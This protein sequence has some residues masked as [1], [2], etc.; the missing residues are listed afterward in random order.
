MS[1]NPDR[2]DVVS[3]CTGDCRFRI[4]CS[5]LPS[6]RVKHPDAPTDLSCS[7]YLV[8]WRPSSVGKSEVEFQSM[9]ISASTTLPLNM[10]A[11]CAVM[12]AVAINVMAI[13]V[14]IRLLIICILFLPRGGL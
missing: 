6:L 3:G 14:I 2:M 8:F 4:A 12:P 11:A 1:V 10:V 7:A 5:V 9:S 13:M